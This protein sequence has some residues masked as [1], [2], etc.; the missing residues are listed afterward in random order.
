MQVHDGSGR[1][2]AK[3]PSSSWAERWLQMTPGWDEGLFRLAHGRDRVAVAF[4]SLHLM[5]GGD[6][7]IELLV[8]HPIFPAW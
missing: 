5:A 8:D 6:Q 1:H 7:C 2:I 4:E 3:T